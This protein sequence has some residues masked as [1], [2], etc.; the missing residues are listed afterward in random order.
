MPVET[1]PR[2]DL[3]GKTVLIT[4]ASRGIGRACALAC[5][6]SGADLIVGVRKAA[7]GKALTAE[8]EGLGRRA[9]AVEMDLT[10][11]SGMR[12]AVAKAHKAFGRIDVLVNN[13][14]LGPEN[15]AENVTEA[16]FDLTVDVNLKGTFFTTQAVGRL[17]IA[18]KSG[19]IINISS[20][21]GSVTLK[22][23]AIY[24]MSK[25]AINHLTRCLAAEWAEHGITVNS[26]APTFIWTDGTRPSLADPGFHAHVL[27]HIPLG[28]I[29]DPIDVAGT[30]VFL[31]SPAA[32]LI[33]GANIMVDGGWS[34]A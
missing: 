32:S 4:G 25:A 9:L 17:M 13:V 10:D 28:R 16:D 1:T 27:G 5:A 15:L 2:F 26:V 20:Q 18:Q 3:E 33:T 8:I 19:R 21:A 7:D 11:L 31:A 23:E 12:E 24:C 6:G 22:G 30:V 29:G 34:V 14:G